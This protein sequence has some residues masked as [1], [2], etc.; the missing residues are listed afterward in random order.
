MDAY[1]MAKQS[2]FDWAG[3]RSAVVNI[4]DPKGLALLTHLKDNSGCKVW[5]VGMHPQAAIHARDVKT[6]EAGMS[7]EVVEDS[8]VASIVTDAVGAFNVLNLLGVVAALRDL[9]FSLQQAVQACEGLQAVPGRMQRL[10]SFAQP[11]VV[12]DYAHTP[13]AI[14]KALQALRPW[15]DARA[16]RLICVLGCGGDRDNSKR[17]PMARAGV[18]D[19]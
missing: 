1:W 16:G 7:F 3:L 18:F 12:V 14:E 13:D 19:Q 5:T 15:A 10:G 11:A 4:D 6:V 9:G 2:L 8:S 17:A